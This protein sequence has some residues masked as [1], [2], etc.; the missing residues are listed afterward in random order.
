VAGN[1]AR[2]VELAHAF[3][4]PQDSLARGAR[5]MHSAGKDGNLPLRKHLPDMRK[6]VDNARMSAPKHDNKTGWR[7]E[8]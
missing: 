8:N 3:N 4:G 2:D 7:V 5:E 6:R 1:H